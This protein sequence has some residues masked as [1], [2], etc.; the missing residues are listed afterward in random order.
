MLVVVRPR[1]VDLERGTRS[2]F[3]TGP[4]D[5]F[6]AIWSPDGR[7]ISYNVEHSGGRGYDIVLRPTAAPGQVETLVSGPVENDFTKN[8]ATSPF[9]PPF[10]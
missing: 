6:T 8:A 7:R 5:K 3:T 9:A 10:E 4:G 2:R 1:R